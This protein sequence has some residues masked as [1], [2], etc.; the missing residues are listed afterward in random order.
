M[1]S[2]TEQRQHDKVREAIGNFYAGRT[3]AKTVYD[4]G[5]L[6]RQLQSDVQMG[7]YRG[8]KVSRE[9]IAR[10]VRSAS[11]LAAVLYAIRSE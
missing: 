6:L 8:M 2:V 1:L 10:M 5:A 9:Q 7:Q 3:L 11:D 4:I